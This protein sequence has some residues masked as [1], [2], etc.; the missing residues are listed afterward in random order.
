MSSQALRF[1]TLTLLFLPMRRERRLGQFARDLR[2]RVSRRRVKMLLR[3]L[4]A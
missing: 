4:Y 1:H 3:N 2:L